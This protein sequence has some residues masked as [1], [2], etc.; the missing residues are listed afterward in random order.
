VT[1]PV[2]GVELRPDGFELLRLE[3]LHLDPCN[4]FASEPRQRCV[5]T[6]AACAS[7][8]RSAFEP[9]FVIEPRR[10]TSPHA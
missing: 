6:C 7:V 3:G 8:D 2:L 5:S 10:C 1:T 4:G 9:V